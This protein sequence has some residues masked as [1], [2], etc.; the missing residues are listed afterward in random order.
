[1]VDEFYIP[2]E[3]YE[4]KKLV[5][6]ERTHQLYF[7]IKQKFPSIDMIKKYRKYLKAKNWVPCSD[8]N[9]VW[10]SHIDISVNP[11]MLVHELTNYWVSEKKDRLLILRIA[12]YSNDLKQRIPDNSKQRVIIWV[13]EAVGQS[14]EEWK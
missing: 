2:S 11:K 6:S 12:Y 9:P 13:Q 3:A 7:Q 8:E 1:M 10:R 4:I 14:C 5:L